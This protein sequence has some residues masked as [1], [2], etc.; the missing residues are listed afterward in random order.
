[1]EGHNGSAGSGQSWVTVPIGGEFADRRIRLVSP[2]ALS[3]GRLQ[4]VDHLS[5]NDQGE[6]AVPDQNGELENHPFHFRAVGNSALLGFSKFLK[7]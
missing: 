7:Y 4:L 5:Q 2:P 6:V 3:V 1:M